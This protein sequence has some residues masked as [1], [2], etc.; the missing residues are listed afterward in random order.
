MKEALTAL[1][2]IKTSGRKI[3]VLGDMLELGEKTFN[4]HYQLGKEVSLCKIDVLISV[5]EF[6]LHT[7]KGAEEG[8]MSEENIFI[9]DTTEKACQMIL[10]F[11]KPRDTLLIKGSRKM[12]M[13]T[14]IDIL[15]LKFAANEAEGIW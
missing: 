8:G 9:F 2:N 3:A 4:F 6:A 10:E 1:K 15:K 7:A 12:R 11:L 13:E 5:G 14:I